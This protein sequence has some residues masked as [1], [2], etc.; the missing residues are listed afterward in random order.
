MSDI[1][2][3]N[4]VVGARIIGVAVLLIASVGHSANDYSGA[5]GISGSDALGISGSDALGTS[6]SDALGI[7]GSDALGI[8]GSDALGI[9]G[10]DALGISGSDA[11]G[12]SG[13]DALGISGSDALGISGSDAL[14]ISG[15][16]ALGISGSDALA[17]TGHGIYGISGSDALGISGSDALGIS[18]SDALGISGS[19]ALGISGSDALGISG[20][21]ALGISG[22]DAELLV[23]GRINHIGNG[24]I[25]VLGQTVFGNLSGLGA[26]ATVAVYGSIDAD[27]GGIV[28]AQVVPVGAGSGAS[29]LRGI[30]D[31]VNLAFGIAVISGVTV[32]YNA[33]LSD[34]GAPQV[35]DVV[36][37]VGQSYGG[38]LVADPLLS[39]D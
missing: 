24:F 3:D 25:S 13:S 15:S 5:N 37:V 18:G 38:L 19:D 35:G 7:S 16:D 23:F 28:G 14:G 11:L 26:G 29:Y 33:M 9:S 30:V 21:D 6:G 34:G 31:E 12:I 20:S 39:L 22:S 36:G 2:N 4:M 1:S 8:S 10:S 17:A 27:T 32:D